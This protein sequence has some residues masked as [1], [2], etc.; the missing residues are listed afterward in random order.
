MLQI[1]VL[2]LFC[3]NEERQVNDGPVIDNENFGGPKLAD[4][5][6]PEFCLKVGDSFVKSLK[7][8]NVNAAPA[9]KNWL[10]LHRKE[11]NDLATLVTGLNNLWFLLC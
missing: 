11:E 6:T 4:L 9:V 10:Q 3:P 2:T 1:L 8:D 5:F 7:S